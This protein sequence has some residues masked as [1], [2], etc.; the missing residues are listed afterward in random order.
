MPSRRVLILAG[1][2]VL[3]IA[4]APIYNG[5]VQ[6]VEHVGL[7]VETHP[8]NCVRAVFTT[9]AD[10]SGFLSGEPDAALGY[11][12]DGPDAAVWKAGADAA[13]WIPPDSGT[14]G[15]RPL[16]KSG[17]SYQCYSALAR[18][19]WKQGVAPASCVYTASFPA[20]QNTAPQSFMTE[21]DGGQAK[22]FGIAESG[23]ATVECCPVIPSVMSGN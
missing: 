14:M 22:V 19:C 9:V 6:R 17:L 13:V 15:P 23:T 4:A 11:P 12:F 3:L 5:A 21:P 18:T 10:A 7:R 20:D 2:A 1:I 8:G 16:P